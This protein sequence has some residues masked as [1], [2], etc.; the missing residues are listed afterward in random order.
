[1]GPVRMLKNALILALAMAVVALPFIFRRQPEAN[2]WEPGDPELIVISAHNE[3]IRFEFG[4]AFSLWHAETYGRPVRIDWRAIGGTSEIMRYLAAEYVSAFRAWY[5]SQGSPWPTNGGSMLLD[6]KF[7]PDRPPDSPDSGRVQTWKTQ[8]GIWTA[9]RGH[10]D[11]DVFSAKIDLFFGGGEY[12]HNKA[13]RQGL[14][15][16]PWAEGTIPPGLINHETGA[17]LIPRGLSGETWRTRSLYGA[18]LST[19][20][21]CYNRDRLEQ[22]GV[23]HPPR[24]WK[25]LANPAYLGQVGVADPTKSGSITK[26]FEMIIHQQCYESIRAAG[27]DD[28]RIAGFEAAIRSHRGPGDLP[29]S[30]PAAYQDALEWGWVQ[31]VLLVQRIGANARY[32]TDSSCKIPIDVCLGDAAVGLSIDFYGRYQAEKS[33]GVDGR[34][35]MRYVTPDGGSSVSADPISLMRGAPNREVALRF[36][37]FVLRTEGQRLW[38]YRPQTPGGPVKFALRRLPVRRDF[39]PSENRVFDETA[40]AHADYTSDDLLSAN[41]NPYELAGR[42][43]YYSRWTASHFGIHRDLIR[44]MCL[45]AGKELRAA[46]RAIVENGGPDAQAEAMEILTRLPDDPVPLSWQSAPGIPKELSRLDY[47]RQWTVFFRN[48]YRQARRIAMGEG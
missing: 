47:M 41:V 12:D 48:N 26:A 24:Q 30:V 31:G 10:D 23:D 17:E 6:R 39:Y 1:M 27:F 16:A 46:W 28:D 25:D 45:D 4:H 38:N 18:A 32:F 36:I 7:D 20:G 13:S 5:R 8:Q 19:F 29:E 42:F 22:L 43:T 35:R 37:E 9:F 21:I 40:R 3:A 44:A 11:P 2:R 33:R 14:T 34:E 15:V